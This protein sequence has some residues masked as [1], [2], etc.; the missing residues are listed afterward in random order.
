M[1]G[2]TTEID[3]SL[4]QKKRLQ[5]K[6]LAMRT[7]TPADKQRI[8]HHFQQHWLPL[9]THG[10]LKPVIDSV[11]PF[12]EA[13]AAHEYMESNLNVGKIILSFE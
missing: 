9:F 6:G 5:I 13:K 8:T 3:L 10:K 4:I 12:T 7:Q 11:F 2:S 1:R